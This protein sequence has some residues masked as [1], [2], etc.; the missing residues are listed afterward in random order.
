MPEPEDEPGPE[1]LDVVIVGA[2]F[3]GLYMLHRVRELGLSVRVLEAGDGIGGT[4]F[5]NRYPGARC[6]VESVDYSYG[7]SAELLDRWRWSERFAT[8]PEI[9]DYLEFVAT[10]LDLYRDIELSTMVVAAH[11]L[12]ES[13]TWRITTDRG[14][15][16][17]ARFCIM[18][19]G[20][21]SLSYVP[22]FTGLEEFRGEWYHTGRWPRDDVD[23]SGKRVAVIG[24]G[25]SGIQA[26][27]EIARAAKQLY[28]FQRTPN[29]TLPARNRPLGADSIQT[30]TADYIEWKRQ[31]R[32]T[33]GGAMP[34]LLPVGDSVRDALPHERER[35]FET[36]W[37]YGGTSMLGSYKDIMSDQESNTAVADFIR[38]KIRDIVHDPRVAEMLEPTDHHVGAKRICVDTDY[39]ETFNRENVALVDVRTSP[40]VGMT[41]DGISTG[42]DH[43]SVDVIVFATGYDAMTGPMLNIDLRGR[44]GLRLRDEWSAGPVMYLGLA[45]AGFPNLFAITGPGSPSVRANMATAIEQHVEWIADCLAFLEAHSMATIEADRAA[46]SAWVAHVADVANQTFFASANSWYLGANISGKPRVFMPYLGG[47]DVYSR[48]CQQVADDGYEGFVLRTS[49]EQAERDAEARP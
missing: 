42:E 11:Y 32:N 47:F 45:V 28:V 23:F 35:E 37:E 12:D 31:G 22:P 33:A 1:S 39:F 34:M 24:T 46:Q 27:P 4:W 7:F 20:C 21:L 9:L 36:R 3:A 41:A 30:R 29:F 43:Y 16:Y 5:W 26:I 8:Q 38:R 40:I 48:T 14:N 44:S 13:Q 18:A 15:E 19:T 6:D 2:G 17:A 10:E 25:S 49:D